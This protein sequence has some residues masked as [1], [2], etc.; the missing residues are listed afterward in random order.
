MLLRRLHREEAQE[1]GKLAAVLGILVNTKLQVLAECL[2]EFLEV[3]LVLRNLT[4]EVH[5]VLDDVLADDFVLLECFAGGVEGE[6]FGIDNA[7][8][9]VKVF[10]NNLLCDERRA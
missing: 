2:L 10:R 5:A 8:D 3:V 9:E 1:L 6:I 7:F 4:E